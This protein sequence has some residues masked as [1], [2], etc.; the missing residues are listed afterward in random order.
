MSNQPQISKQ[1]AMQILL[2]GAKRC[3]AAAVVT[4]PSTEKSAASRLS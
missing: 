3:L 1:P 4:V 2:A